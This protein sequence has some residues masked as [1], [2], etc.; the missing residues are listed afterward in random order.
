MSEYNA[1][2]Y[3]TLHHHV[4]IVWLTWSVALYSTAPLFPSFA[5]SFQHRFYVTF[6]H[7][8]DIIV[9]SDVVDD[10]DS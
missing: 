10:D 7:N 9:D 3:V 6:I 1:H 8:S 2:K 5:S 4:I